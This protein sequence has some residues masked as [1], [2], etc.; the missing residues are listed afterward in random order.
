MVDRRDVVAAAGALAL[1]GCAV[2]QPDRRPDGK[3]TVIEVTPDFRIEITPDPASG[4]A[5]IKL[6]GANGER[7][8]TEIDAKARHDDPAFDRG[9]ALLEVRD[10]TTSGK[11]DKKWNRTTLRVR[12][13]IGARIKGEPLRA[14][15]GHA[16]PV[17]VE[18]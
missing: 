16:R 10:L 5:S 2:A 8:L 3:T 11:R 13:P 12:F 6:I 9:D 7:F 14:H 15:S 4:A 17:I 1:A 18:C